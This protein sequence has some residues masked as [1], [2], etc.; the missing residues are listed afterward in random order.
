MKFIKL[1][2]LALAFFSLLSCNQEQSLQEYYID[3]KEND[4]FI[5]LDVPTSLIAPAS[6]KLSADQQK[7]VESVKKINLL[8]YSLKDTSFYN[9]ETA[10]LKTILQNDDY[11]ELMKVGNTEQRMRIFIKGDE[12]A[13]DEVV[14]FA[15]DENKGFLVARVL[16][17]NMN[18]ADMVRFAETMDTSS[19]T[20]N[21]G[22]FEGIMDV[23]K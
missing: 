20:L 22:S 16:G 19:A 2:V 21:T 13:I 18:V 7:V 3:S 6:E 14:V 17:D 10:K 5:M 11:D 12:D 15:Q 4:D 8:A 9:T 23:F 1:S